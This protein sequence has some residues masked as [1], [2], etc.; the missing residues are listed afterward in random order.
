LEVVAGVLIPAYASLAIISSGKSNTEEYKKWGSYW[1]SFAILK[2][3]VFAA[4]NIL[5]SAL[6]PVLLFV[7]VIAILYLW[8]PFTNGSLMLWN[9]FIN[10]QDYLNTAKGLVGMAVSKLSCCKGC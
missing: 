6:N 3:V 8:L 9:K 2:K 10:N 5:P 4:L 7:R 1:I